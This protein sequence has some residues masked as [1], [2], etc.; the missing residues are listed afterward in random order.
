MLPINISDHARERLKERI[1]VSER[2]LE[3]L[4]LKAWLSKEPL[5][6]HRNQKL[7][8]LEERKMPGEVMHIRR[9]M[10]WDF[11]FG[12]SPD[13]VCLITVIGGGRLP[14]ETKKGA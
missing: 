4:V 7:H 8:A 5:P 14:R 9:L 10:G 13:H 12:E 3:R 2:K 11:F 1:G 6:N